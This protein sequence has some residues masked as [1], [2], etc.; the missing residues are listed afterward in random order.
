M[1]RP[2][3][4]KYLLYA[5]VLFLLFLGYSNCSD[6]D[7]ADGVALSPLDSRTDYLECLWPTEL[8]VGRLLSETCWGILLEDEFAHAFYDNF[9]LYR[10]SHP[11]FSDELETTKHWVYW[12]EGSKITVL[13]NSGGATIAE[14]LQLSGFGGLW[15]FPVGTLFFQEFSR[16]NLKVET[17]VLLKAS[18]GVGFDHWRPYTFYWRAD[19]SDGVYLGDGSNA[20]SFLQ[21][22]LG[23]EGAQYAYSRYVT[24]DE[25]SQ[26][27]GFSR[28]RTPVTSDCLQCHGGTGDG[29]IGFNPVQLSGDGDGLRISHLLSRDAFDGAIVSD[30]SAQ[31]ETIEPQ[32]WSLNMELHNRCGVCHNP[33]AI[34]AS[35]LGGGDG[36]TGASAVRLDVSVTSNGQLSL[37]TQ[38]FGQFNW[39]IPG[40][41]EEPNPLICLLDGSCTDSIMPPTVDGLVRPDFQ[42]I[43]QLEAWLSDQ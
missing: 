20:E 12:P 36:A 39:L 8:P 2:V 24:V 11:Q 3:P 9:F 17:R 32:E 15:D 27:V 34:E 1:V 31:I 35:G 6:F 43:D 14:S 23:E 4:V 5:F 26:E 42:L 19:Q 22:F 16:G 28:Y 41:E 33:R 29:V 18:A 7:S 38:G 40:T 25:Q 21:N 10:P 13:P 37:P 30:L